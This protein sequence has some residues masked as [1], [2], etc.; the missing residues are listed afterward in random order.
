MATITQNLIREIK[1]HPNDAKSMSHSLAYDTFQYRLIAAPHTIVIGS[2]ISASVSH[3]K[4]LKQR[5]WK[6]LEVN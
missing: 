3:E 2:R 1:S 5:F 6:H 4:M